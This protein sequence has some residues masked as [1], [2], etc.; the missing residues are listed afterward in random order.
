MHKK[1]EQGE[2]MTEEIWSPDYIRRNPEL[3]A[4]AIKS[5]QMILTNMEEELRILSERLKEIETSD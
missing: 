5:L 3:T 4:T 1:S 2:S